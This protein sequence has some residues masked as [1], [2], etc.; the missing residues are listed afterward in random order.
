MSSKKKKIVPIKQ[1]K[2]KP[3][4]KI[5]GVRK[6][7]DFV[8][9]DREL[10][11]PLEALMNKNGGCLAMFAPPGSGKGNLIS[12]LVLRQDFMRDLFS[13]GTYFISPTAKND[14]Q[15][16]VSLLLA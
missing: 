11:E 5:Y 2:E 8:K 4:F 7:E 6:E 3:D 9:F 16:L 12:N 14:L 13:G 15:M 1:Q 10:P